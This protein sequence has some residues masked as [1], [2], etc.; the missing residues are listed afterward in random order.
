MHEFSYKL[1][2]GVVEELRTSDMHVNYLKSAESFKK[3]SGL[4]SIVQATT[5][6]S[7]AVHSAQAATSDGDPVT[8]FSM[9]VGGKWVSGSFW[10]VGFRAGDEVQ[11][12]GYQKGNDFIAVA[13]IDVKEN[14]IWMQ[15]HSE[16]G[17]T[18]KKYHLLI[19][20]GYFCIGLYIL[21]LGM[22]FFW[23]IPLWLMLITA[24]I[25]AP[26]ILFATVGLSWSDF[27]DFSKEMDR[28]GKAL[29]IAE[30]EKIDLFKSTRKSRKS[31]KPALPMGVYYL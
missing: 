24:T 30:P 4:T 3:I 19:C 12:V 29:G 16:R 22:G 27:M 23:N 8:S 11:L 7:G 15:P 10:E 6:E 5:G 20:S 25:T 13:V 9:S 21:T 17:T 18:A 2:S 26:V 31:G 14:K 28:V 1:V